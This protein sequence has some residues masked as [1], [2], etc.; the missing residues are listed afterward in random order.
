MVYAEVKHG[1]LIKC[2]KT[3]IKGICQKGKGKRER[4]IIYF[5]NIR[6]T[7]MAGAKS[8]FNSSCDMN[9]LPIKQ[10]SCWYIECQME[11]GGT[12]PS[13]LGLLKIVLDLADPQYPEL[14]CI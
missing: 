6:M 5:T 11:H 14:S 1:F 12:P 13:S 8:M 2:N 4:E 3:V 9:A 7:C 10:F